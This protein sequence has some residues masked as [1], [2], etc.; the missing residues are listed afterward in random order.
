M[1]FCNG[2][3]LKLTFSRVVFV[4]WYIRLV[5]YIF[6]YVL[7]YWRLVLTGGF[8]RNCQ[9]VLIFLESLSPWTWMMF[10]WCYAMYFG[11]ARCRMFC[12]SLV[13]WASMAYRQ[14]SDYR[15]D[16]G[17]WPD[18]T[19]WWTL[20]FKIQNW[21]QRSIISFMVS[22]FSSIILGVRNYTNF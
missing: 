21:H 20:C 16:I 12:C 10:L 11:L 17:I 18:W 3:Y 22:Y 14:S 1:C 2:E 8:W 19:V 9:G 6:C 4:A 13:A 7:A 15:W 5:F